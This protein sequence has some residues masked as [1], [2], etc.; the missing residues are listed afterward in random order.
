MLWALARKME[1]WKLRVMSVGTLSS[2]TATSLPKKRLSLYMEWLAY[3]PVLSKWK[4]MPL[5]WK[6]QPMTLAQLVP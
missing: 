3:S 4:P 6:V 1:P 2:R 5:L